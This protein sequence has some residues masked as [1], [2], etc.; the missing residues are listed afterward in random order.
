VEQRASQR[1]AARAVLPLLTVL[2]LVGMHGIPDAMASPSGAT[3]VR[4]SGSVSSPL[5]VPVTMP[6]LVSGRVLARHAQQAGSDAHRPLRLTHHEPQSADPS[7]AA[8]MGCGMDHAGCL[9]VLRDAGHLVAES[10]VLT[11]VAAA[12]MPTPSLVSTPARGPRA[13]PDV[14]LIG[15]GISRT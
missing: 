4:S 3:A 12:G 10:P 14:S 6:M 7:I 13:P 11:V 2:G 8:P 15:L 1:W 9:A 5:A